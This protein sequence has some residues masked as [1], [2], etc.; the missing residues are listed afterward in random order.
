MNHFEYVVWGIAPNEI[1]DRVLIAR[2]DGKPITRRVVADRALA[3][4]QLRG[5]TA[6][7]IQK[8]NMGDN[9]IFRR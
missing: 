1:E 9:Q 4:C 6:C 8:V 3:A 5:A 7:R 2:I